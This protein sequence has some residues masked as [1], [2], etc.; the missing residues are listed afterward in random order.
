MVDVVTKAA[1][2]SL[3]GAYRAVWR[4]HFYAGVFVMPFLMLL[5]LTGG[6]YLFKDE[7]D[8]AVYRSMIQVPAGAVQ[9]SPDAWLA[10]AARAGGG[11]VANVVLPDRPDQ[12]VRARVDQPDGTQKTVFI[13][14]HTARVTG[15]TGYGGVME[16]IKRLHSLELF[17]PVMNILVEIVAGWAIILFATGLYLWWPRGHHR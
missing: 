12:A 11:R 4:W 6:L 5:A 2:D 10:A 14:P 16:T 13:D 7:I 9:T 3:S 15:V 1:P 17:G 8:Q